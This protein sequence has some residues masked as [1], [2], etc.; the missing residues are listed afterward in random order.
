M[1]LCCITIVPGNFIL[2]SVSDWI[3]LL[4]VAVLWLESWYDLSLKTIVCYVADDVIV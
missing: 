3:M 2:K 4:P 1:W